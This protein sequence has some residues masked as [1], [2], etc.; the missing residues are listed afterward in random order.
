MKKLAVF[1]FSFAYDSG[2]PYGMDY[3]KEITENENIYVDFN[4]IVVGLK[5]KEQLINNSDKGSGNTLQSSSQAAE[6]TKVQSI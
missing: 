3:A 4:A 1:Y 2:H 5:K 6:K